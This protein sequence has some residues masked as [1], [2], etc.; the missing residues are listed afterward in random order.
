MVSLARKAHRA[1]DVLRWR[2][3]SLRRPPPQEAHFVGPIARC[4]DKGLRRA[5]QVHSHRRSGTHFVMDTLRA[6]FD[7][8][9]DWF[10]LEEDFYARLTHKPVV[11][12]SHERAWGEKIRSPDHWHCYM[13]WVAASACYSSA[14][15]IHVIRNPRDVM[16]SQYYFDMK[17]HEAAFRIEPETQFLAYLT[18]PSVRDPQGRLTPLAYWCAHMAAWLAQPDV[19]MVRYEDLLADP[20]AELARLSLFLNMPVQAARRVQQSAIGRQTSIRMS[21]LFQADWGAREEQHLLDQC[22]R[23]NLPDLGYGLAAGAPQEATTLP[24]PKL[25]AALCAATPSLACGEGGGGDKR[26]SE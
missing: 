20:Q 17:G 23:F 11:L 14:F 15:H 2:H 4:D 5:I 9:R 6:N 22:R 3:L 26:K 7:V 25:L 13:H 12:K 24:R 18:T 10:H 8:D 19:H 1:W 21:K 16:R